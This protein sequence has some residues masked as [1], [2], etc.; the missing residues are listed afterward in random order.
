MKGSKWT[1]E[2]W[3]FWR[4]FKRAKHMK[5]YENMNIEYILDQVGSNN[6]MSFHTIL[7]NSEDYYTA[8]LRARQLTD[9]IT[10][11]INMGRE[12]EDHVNVFPYS[13]FYVFYEQY[14]TMWQDTLHSIGVSLATIF[15]VTFFLMGMDLR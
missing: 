2:F 5:I 6:F 13:V 7:K 1:P 14:L 15:V 10:E 12:P 9:S 8:L 4:M 11:R 3:S